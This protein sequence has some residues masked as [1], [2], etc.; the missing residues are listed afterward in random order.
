MV[1]GGRKYGGNTIGR[2]R[3]EK[4]SIYVFAAIV[5]RRQFRNR[6]YGKGIMACRWLVG[7]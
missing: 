6:Y 3:S 1:P 4:L 2:Y 5:E 7:K